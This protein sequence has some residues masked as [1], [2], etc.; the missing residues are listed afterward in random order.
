VVAYFAFIQGHFDALGITDK[1]IE[2]LLI[3]L[4]VVEDRRAR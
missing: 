4:L 1:L 3:A 2:G